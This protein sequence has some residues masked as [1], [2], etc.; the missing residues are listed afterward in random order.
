LL[1]TEPVS[2]VVPLRS[3]SVL[4]SV[5]TGARFLGEKGSPLRLG[6]AALIVLGITAIT[7]FGRP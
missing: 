1:R 2:Y 7:L 3:V 4:L 6:A 5:L